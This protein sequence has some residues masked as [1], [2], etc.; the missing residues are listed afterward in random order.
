[1]S[2]TFIFQYKLQKFASEASKHFMKYM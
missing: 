2:H 1:M